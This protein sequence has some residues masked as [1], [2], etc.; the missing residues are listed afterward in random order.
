M[1]GRLDSPPEGHSLRDLA[2]ITPG[3]GKN[4]L[5]YFVLISCG[6]GVS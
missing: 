6:E 3:L 1:Q 5:F 4:Y 2:S